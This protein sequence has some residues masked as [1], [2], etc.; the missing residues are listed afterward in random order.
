VIYLI[1]II[2]VVNSNHMLRG[3][4]VK[5]VVLG[6]GNTL[7]GD[8]AAGILALQALADRWHQ[9]EDI[10]FV[11]GGTLSFTLADTIQDADQLIVID[12]AQLNEPAG[13]VRVFQNSEMDAFVSTGQCG[14]VHEVSLAE[15]MDIARLTESVP[16]KRALVGIQPEFLGVSPEPTPP[17]HAAI[18]LAVEKADA[19]LREWH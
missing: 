16:G 3:K 13:A 9:R 1:L 6:L 17:V 7:M 10:D 15:L 5:T 11:D 2:N 4:R 18:S 12:A 14:S 19:I 8:D